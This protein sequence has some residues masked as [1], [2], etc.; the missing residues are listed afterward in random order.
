MKD[1]ILRFLL[2]RGISAGR[3]DEQANDDNPDAKVFEDKKDDAGNTFVDTRPKWQ[4]NRERKKWF[5]RARW[6]FALFARQ[7]GSP[8][9]P[10]P[11][12]SHCCAGPSL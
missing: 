8:P 1:I 2:M 10:P 9:P 11:P 12:C 3:P 5:V 7:C 4:R 6:V